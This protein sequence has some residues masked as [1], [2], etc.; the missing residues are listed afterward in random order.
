MKTYL[1]IIG[2]ILIVGLICIG[3]VSAIKIVD[4]N[5]HTTYSTKYHCK[6]VISYVTYKYNAYKLKTRLKIRWNNGKR[7]TAVMEF[8]KI[9]KKKIRM[10]NTFRTDW[11]NTKQRYYIKTRWT[12]GKYY[13]RI[14]KPNLRRL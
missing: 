4:K 6:G 8:L 2:I 13:T 3:P 7:G 5:T 1:K 12:L 10:T 14:I 11:G 9:N